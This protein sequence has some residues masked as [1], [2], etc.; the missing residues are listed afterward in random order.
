MI[1]ANE[2]G[3]GIRQIYPFDVYLKGVLLALVAAGAVAFFLLAAVKYLIF[4][5]SSYTIWWVNRWPLLVHVIC[6]SIALFAG[7]VQFIALIRNRYLRV[8]R[9]IGAMYVGS[10]MI[11]SLSGYY[12]AF[13]SVVGPLLGYSLV[14]LSTA[15]LA[16]TL[17]ALACILQYRIAEHRLW[18]TR[19]YIV[20]FAFVGFRFLFETPFLA[21]FPP[22]ERSAVIIWF[23]WIPTLLVFEVGRQVHSLVSRKMLP[24]H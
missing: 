18:M 24:A 8:H 9:A 13:N 16:T 7:P 4:T 15:W 23:A 22:H 2:L 11:G 12:L 19:S 3:R 17:V 10:V 5:E 14:V 1:D 6:G 21:D 20:T